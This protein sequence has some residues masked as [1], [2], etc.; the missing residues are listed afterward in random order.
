MEDL[1][2]SLQCFSRSWWRFTI[3][4]SFYWSWSIAYNA[5]FRWWLVLTLSFS[6]CSRKSQYPNSC[7]WTWIL[8]LS[9]FCL[10]G[11]MCINLTRVN[12]GLKQRTWGKHVT[13]T[14]KPN[15]RSYIWF[16]TYITLKEV[17]FIY[18]KTSRILHELYTFFNIFHGLLFVHDVVPFHL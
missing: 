7:F 4:L 17:V 18:D 6:N 12:K 16:K 2:V 5:L 14:W 11:V 10:K 9:I 13:K 1:V 3:F 15:Q 8:R